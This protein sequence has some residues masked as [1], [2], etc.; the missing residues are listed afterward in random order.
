MTDSS[1]NVRSDTE[2]AYDT[3]WQHDEGNELVTPALVVDL[4]AFDHN[5][6]AAE[7]LLRGTGKLLRPHVKT[8]RT[9]ALTLRQ[10]GPIA[11]GVTCATVREAEV[12]AA[13]GIKDLLLANEIVTAQKINRMVALAKQGRTIVAVDSDEG[14]AALSTAARNGGVTVD[15]LVDID[16]GL[17]RCG[18]GNVSRACEM[19][20]AISHTPAL[21]FAGLMGYEGRVRASAADRSARIARSFALLAEAK[22]SIQAAGLEVGIVSAAGTSTLPEAA[23]DP[24]I[25]E[26]QA[27][28]Y[29][30]ME[31]DLEGLGLPFR[32]ALFIIATVISRSAGRVVLDAGRRTAGCDNGLP[33]ALDPRAHTKSAGDEHVTLEWK[34]DLPPL[35]GQVRLRP[36]Q[37]RTTFNL[38]RQVWLMRDERIVGRY[39]VDAQGGSQ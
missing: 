34:G 37:N 36:T 19:A 11:G 31:P 32:C 4:A 6:A 28:S 27:G 17:G 20:I 9:S 24:T 26:I 18:V 5:L 13:A 1:S 21:R 39:P 38:Y 33:I 15:V 23:R 14:V 2:L 12:M 29:A 7:N 3:E 30:L 8:H 10:M 25:T 22:A 16:V 35:G